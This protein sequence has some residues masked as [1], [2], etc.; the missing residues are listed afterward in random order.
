[1]KTWNV[2]VEWK[3]RAYVEVNAATLGAARKQVQDGD[4]PDNGEYIEDSMRV[5]G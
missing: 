4:V 1:M 2:E 3:M 5:T